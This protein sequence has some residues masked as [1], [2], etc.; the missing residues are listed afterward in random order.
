M[1]AAG[2]TAGIG[3]GR[4]PGQEVIDLSV[5][6]A[7]LKKAIVTI[8]VLI[9]I[10]LYLIRSNMSETSQHHRVTT[11]SP[12]SFSNETETTTTPL[13]D[14]ID[15]DED[16]KPSITATDSEWSRIRRKLNFTFSEV[17]KKKHAT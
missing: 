15:T 8:P 9:M 17:L 1:P 12:I 7:I 3:T 11:G 4:L 2:A 10:I 13:S 14:I 16:D 5:C 6:L